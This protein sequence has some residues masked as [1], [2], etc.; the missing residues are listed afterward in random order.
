MTTGQNLKTGR[1]YNMDGL[2]SFDH[3]AIERQKEL[4]AKTG[5][6]SM[7]EFLEWMEYGYQEDEWTEI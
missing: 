4:L 1:R 6:M 2:Y 3:D 7:P 5:A